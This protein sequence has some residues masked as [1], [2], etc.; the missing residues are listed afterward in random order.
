MDKLY[1]GLTYR[2]GTPVMLFDREGV[3]FVTKITHGRRPYHVQMLDGNRYVCSD[4]HLRVVTDPDARAEARS[5]YFDSLTEEAS[6]VVGMVVTVKGRDSA[7]VVISSPKAGRV[8][9]AKMGGDNGRYL[10]CPITM[11]MKEPTDA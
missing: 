3:G 5:A 11:L 8:N 10:T 6:F 4:A 1:V 2:V 9:V 7:Y